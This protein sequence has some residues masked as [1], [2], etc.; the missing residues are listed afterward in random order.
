MHIYFKKIK[1]SF[2][3]HKKIKKG[4]QN[5][6]THIDQY[7]TNEQK[8]KAATNLT[9]SDVKL[10]CLTCGFSTCNPQYHYGA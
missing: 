8:I 2:V 5:N 4:L 10:P 3:E 1:D 9:Q 6:V 7:K